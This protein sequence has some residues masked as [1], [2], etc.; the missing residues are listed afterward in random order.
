MGL[1]CGIGFSRSEGDLGLEAKDNLPVKVSSSTLFLLALNP[2]TLVIYPL[3][4]VGVAGDSGNKVSSL[5]GWHCIQCFFGQE[6][7]LLSWRFMQ[8]AYVSKRR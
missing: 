3:D 5:L 7:C 8:L 1:G 2:D 4:P 6:F